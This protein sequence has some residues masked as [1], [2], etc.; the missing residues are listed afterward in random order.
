MGA[1][2]GVRVVR[3]EGHDIES[4]KFKNRDKQMPFIVRV[5]LRL[6][7]IIL[8]KVPNCQEVKTY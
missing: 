6:L 7:L 3:Y 8:V 4:R 2:A 1:A 5:M